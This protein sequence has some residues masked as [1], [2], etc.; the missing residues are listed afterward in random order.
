MAD[1]LRYFPRPELAHELV[2]SVSGKRLFDSGVSGLF[3]AAPRRTGKS[4]F[5]RRDLGPALENA[6]ACVVY[7]DL[8]EQR[9][10]DP[11]IRIAE[12]VA[13]ATSEAQGVVTRMRDKLAAAEIDINGWLGLRAEKIGDVDGPTFTV[14]LNALGGM[15][16]GP[17]A[18]IVDEAQQALTSVEG[19]Q[20][21]FGL[22]AAR[23]AM[24]SPDDIR[25]MLIMTGSDRD[26]LLRLV[27][28]GSA[29][30][31]GAQV[32]SMPTLGK[33]YVRFVATAVERVRPELAPV[34]P[35][36]MMRAFIALDEW[37]ETFDAELGR[38]LHPL[39]EPSL[40]H[41]EVRLE[42]A[43]IE[44][45]IVE[46]DRMSKRFG[47]LP[48]LQR[49]ALWR[50]LEQRERFRPH[51]RAAA[52]F[53]AQA[54]D[55]L[56][57]HRTVDANKIGRAIERLRAASPPLAWRSARGEYALEDAAMQSWY[58]DLVAAGKWPPV[59]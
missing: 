55:M 6:G 10:T 48:P 50:L 26:R 19:E 11:G 3:L 21:M 13:R 58:D 34:D 2:L 41:Y 20:A 25:L 45:R 24:N 51:D 47:S 33:D 30:F 18:L 7:V 57:E 31:L 42:G 39:H 43:A 53:Y 15:T 38:A 23:D 8:W 59:A 9:G 4:T 49:I 36:A 46:R 22:K 1:P 44:H 35:A 17:V 56:G 54:L 52:T 29:P 12:A 40:E 16:R 28:S 37:P 32:R 5:L 27:S 14:A